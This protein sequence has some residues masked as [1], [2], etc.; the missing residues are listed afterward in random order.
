M[1]LTT[2]Q[3]QVIELAMQGVP[4]KEIAQRLSVAYNTVRVHRVNLLRKIGAKSMAQAVAIYMEA[5]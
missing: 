2:R 3:T 4:N 1:K 5:K